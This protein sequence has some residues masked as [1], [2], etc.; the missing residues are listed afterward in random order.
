MVELTGEFGL[1]DTAWNGVKQSSGAVFKIEQVRADGTVTQLFSRKLDPAR[2]PADRGVQAFHVTLPAAPGASLRLITHAADPRDNS[3]NYTFW[4]GFA[5]ADFPAHLAFEG[6]AIRS[7]RSDAVNGFAEMDEA[8]A[9]VL[10]AHAPSELIFPLDPAARRLT[11]TIGLIHGAYTGQ[12]QTEG[13]VFVVAVESV[14]GARRELFRR[15]LNPRQVLA[16]QGAVDFG[17]DL[18]ATP[19]GR[20]ILSTESAPSGNLNSAW[21]YW[22]KLELAR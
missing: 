2:A 14:D 10:F 18:P 22:G 17:V 4:H 8:G 1:L 11:G 12:G 15:Y 5:L 9:R 6:K 13:A 20:L 21:S 3:F 19:G 16:D 7:L